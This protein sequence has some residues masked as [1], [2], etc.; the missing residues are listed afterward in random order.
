MHDTA[1][2][3][4][5]P[6]DQQPAVPAVVGPELADQLLARAEAG[7]VELAGPDGLLSRVTKAVLE[8][9]LAE[10]ITGHLGYGRHDP[11]GRGSGDSRNGTTAKTVLAGVGA[12]GLAVP[13]DRSGSSGPQIA[14]KG[15]TRLEGSATGSSP[16]MRGHDGPRYPRA[17]AG[18]A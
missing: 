8:R 9:A 17:P 12:V 3:P 5:K 14:C 2:V 16:C 15:Q 10:E 6:D 18:D 7:G 11:A 4:G 13:R 1:K